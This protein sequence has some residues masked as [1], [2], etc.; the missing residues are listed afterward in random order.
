MN[1]DMREVSFLNYVGRVYS[2]HHY[3]SY[4]EMTGM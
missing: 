4:D 2:L 1:E 3:S